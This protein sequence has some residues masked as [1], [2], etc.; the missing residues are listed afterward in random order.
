MHPLHADILDV[1]PLVLKHTHVASTSDQANAYIEL[2][3][4]MVID[5]GLVNT[6]LDLN[7]V[8]Q[9]YDVAIN[10]QGLILPSGQL[11]SEQKRQLWKLLSE[12]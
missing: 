8:Q 11:N 2:S 7:V 9:G 10:G 12:S 5:I 4:Q 3:Q 6:Q 1:S